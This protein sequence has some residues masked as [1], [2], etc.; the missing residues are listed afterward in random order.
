[1]FWNHNNR[2]ECFVGIFPLFDDWKSSERICKF[3]DRR[4]VTVSNKTLNNRVINQ[5]FNVK[6]WTIVGVSRAFHLNWKSIFT[7]FCI[8][9]SSWSIIIEYE[10]K[11]RMKLG[12]FQQTANNRESFFRNFSITFHSRYWLF[13]IF[14]VGEKRNNHFPLIE[15]KNWKWK[16]KNRFLRTEIDFQ[17]NAIKLLI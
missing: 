9:H 3:L 7:E 16:K 4:I 1:M 5:C 14:T 6:I 10:L 2:T 17:A 11:R 12:K 8:R 13:K 15:R